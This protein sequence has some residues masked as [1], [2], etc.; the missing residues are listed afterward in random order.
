[1][2]PPSKTL[3]D[4]KDLVHGISNTRLDDIKKT[5]N[6][7]IRSTNAWDVNSNFPDFRFLMTVSICCD[8]TKDT[9]VSFFRSRIVDD[10]VGVVTAVLGT[11]EKT[12]A[13]EE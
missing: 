3:G 2:S 6:L 5:I 1:M 9:S 11:Q 13:V 7:K 10:R 4:L 12:P 8:H